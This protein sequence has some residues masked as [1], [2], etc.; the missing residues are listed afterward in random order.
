VKSRCGGIDSWPLTEIVPTASTEQLE[1]VWRE[2]DTAEFDGE[3]VKTLGQST[4][5]LMQL[6]LRLYEFPDK[7]TGDR[8]ITGAYPKEFLVDYVRGYRRVPG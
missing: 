7:A 6:V 4:S 2:H 3:H 1:H 5:Y 8:T